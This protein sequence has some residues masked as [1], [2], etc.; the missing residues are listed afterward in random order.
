MSFD[1]QLYKGDL[2]I[3]K[4]GKISVVTKNSKLRQDIVKILL[5]QKSS[6][7]YHPNYGSN[8]GA[9]KVGHYADERLMNMDLTAS[10]QTAIRNLMSLQ[11]AQARRQ[12]LS[13]AE[14]IV[15]IK[16]IKVE[17]DMSDPRLYN[18]FISVLTQAFSE[19]T[20]SI[21]IRLI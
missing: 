16:S 17:R 3:T 7:K 18:I 14:I 20:E 4:D 2:K 19:I 11:K 5:T 21:T 9:L 12:L 1:L 13:P 8:L 10:A 15:D 6:I